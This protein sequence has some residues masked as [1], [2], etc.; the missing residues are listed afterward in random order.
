[1]KKRL[2]I[3]LIMALA[4]G[5]LAFPAHAAEKPYYDRYLAQYFEGAE[6][7]AYDDLDTF[8]YEVPYVH[9]TDGKT[10]WALVYADSGVH[11]EVLL[12]AV[13]VGRYFSACDVAYPFEVCYGVYDAE[14]DRFYDFREIEDESRYPDLQEVLD[15]YHVGKRLG[16]EPLFK[17][18]FYR[19]ASWEGEPYN[20][21]ISYSELA[22]HIDPFGG[23]RWV[24]VQGDTNISQETLCYEVVGDRV[25]RDSEYHVPFD[26]T[27]G[28]YDMEVS[29]FYDLTHIKNKPYYAQVCAE[30]DRL[31]LGE[32][33][34]DI[35]RD[36]RLD[37]GDA[38]EH[39]RCIAE[40]D[41][42]PND[43]AVS[44]G[45]YQTRHSQ[46]QAYLTDVNR[47][48]KRDINDVTAVQRILCE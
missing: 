34:G 20:D 41:P 18:A 11:Q 5:L 14:R 8:F 2:S 24:L 25:F 46:P 29:C 19:Y 1:M 6:P 44:A 35:N 10:D 21:V 47:D 7:Y 45:G 30:L 17:D 40:F 16:G 28:V 43:D 37:I 42:Y 31:D 4:A 27:Y 38:T 13:R 48:G 39:Q 3:L 32:K 22:Y 26:L 15:A 23:L 12:N 36:G 9:Q 33:I